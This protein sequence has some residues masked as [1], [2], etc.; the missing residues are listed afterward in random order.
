M[1]FPTVLQRKSGCSVS[2]KNSH[3]QADWW[4]VSTSMCDHK[5][6][7]AAVSEQQHQGDTCIKEPRF[8][9][10]LFDQPV[11]LDLPL[12]TFKVLFLHF[13]FYHNSNSRSCSF[14]PL[15]W[16]WILTVK[17]RLL[18]IFD[19]AEPENPAGTWT[20]YQPGVLPSL[21]GRVQIRTKS[22]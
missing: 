20:S 21:G 3:G 6:P 5:P 16:S 17:L 19:L 13:I 14:V 10:C 1:H 22:I 12:M 4:G 2:S 15:R 11:P 7:T 9:A 8:P 18:C